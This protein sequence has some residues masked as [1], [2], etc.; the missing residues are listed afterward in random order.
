MQYT[1]LKR[2]VQYAQAKQSQPPNFLLLMKH[3]MFLL[4]I[5]SRHSTETEGEGEW[6]P[7]HAESIGWI[8]NN[9]SYYIYWIG[10]RKRLFTWWTQQL[11]NKRYSLCSVCALRCFTNLIHSFPV[12]S[13]QTS[14]SIIMCDVC[15]GVKHFVHK[16]CTKRKRVT[17]T[18]LLRRWWWH[19]L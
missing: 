5:L 13:K 18:S 4:Y 9:I 19:L 11:V 17:C 7:T 10:R 16:V 1:E 14:F 12:I 8:N 6:E 3:F 15:S 2:S